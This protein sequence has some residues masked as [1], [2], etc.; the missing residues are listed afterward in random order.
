M[1][2]IPVFAIVI[3]ILVCI[4][5]FGLLICCAIDTTINVKN[6]L[7]FRK[8]IANEKLEQQV[9]EIVDAKINPGGGILMNDI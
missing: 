5:L 3:C 9:G 8:Q 1:Y 4:F 7:Y 6:Y 2:E